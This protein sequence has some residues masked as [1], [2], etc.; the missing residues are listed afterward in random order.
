MVAVCGETTFGGSTP[1]VRLDELG[2]GM[3]G[4]KPGLRPGNT[5]CIAGNFLHYLSFLMN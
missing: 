5:V 1:E 2:V 4:V 3:R